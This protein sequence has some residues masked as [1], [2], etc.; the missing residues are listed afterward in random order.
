MA[1]WCMLCLTRVFMADEASVV[2]VAAMEAR[3]LADVPTTGTSS[4]VT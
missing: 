1:L 4:T 2:A 3:V